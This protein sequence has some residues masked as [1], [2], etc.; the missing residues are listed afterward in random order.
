MRHLARNE[1]GNS[2]PPEKLF[3]AA[4]RKQWS[5]VVARG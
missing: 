1:E 5:A 4:K 3:L 2:G